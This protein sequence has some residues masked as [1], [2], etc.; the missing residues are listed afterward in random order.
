MKVRQSNYIVLLGIAI[1]LMFV[2]SCEKGPNF[3][4][5]IYPAPLL[6]DFSPKQGYIG[7]AVTIDGKDF[8]T[9]INAV[10]VYFGGVLADSVRS[11][12]D[13][14]IVVLAPKEGITGKISVVVYGKEDTSE[15][16]FT[17]QPSASITA[18]DA[19]KAQKDDEVTITG[20]NFG[21]DISLV[22][23]FIGKVEAEVLEVTPTKIR[24]RVPD[25]PSGNVI[26]MIDGQRLTG[27][28]LMIGIE[29]LIGTIFGH[30]G[31]WNNNPATTITAAF[32]SDME[33]YV[34]GANKIG[35]MGYDF[36][37]GRAGILKSARFAPRS[38]HASRMLNGEIRG[39]N[40][41]SLSDYVVLHQITSVPPA[42]VYS[43]VAIDNETPFRYIYYY[44]GDG[45]GNIAEIEFY[46][47]V[48]DI[49]VTI[50]KYAWEF[51]MDN[52][53]WEPQGAA[54]TISDGA[55]RVIFPQTG[56]NKRRADL[57]LTNLPVT[58]HTGTYPIIAIKMTTLP[59]GAVYTFDASGGAFGNG[60]KKES[61]DY[62]DENVLFWDI[63][64]L[65]QGSNPPVADSPITFNAGQT[66]QFK[67]ADIPADTAPSGYAVE[68]IRTFESKEKL[69]EYLGL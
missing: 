22:S 33:T 2:Y 30:A 48:T 21:E 39:A 17:Y 40:D 3:R 42:G 16:A 55:L 27:P 28:Y 36:G 5:F 8:G 12:T 56:A 63:S 51:N 20:L 68:W 67:I 34:D 64:V 45:N 66:F 7:S 47:N 54:Y 19:D 60:S 49:D 69:A 18:L 35:Y 32:D 38:T 41:P 14:K 46:G 59:P 52:E 9:T 1:L 31:S 61:K 25:A 10:K 24:F 53:G 26:I 6:E 11:V 15:A 23:A 57:K 4:E 62:V 29:K 65:G 58:L 43:E 13:N 37:R 44:T 50:G